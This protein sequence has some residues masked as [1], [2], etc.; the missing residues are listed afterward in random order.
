MTVRQDKKTD[1]QT[2]TVILEE[3]TLESGRVLRQ[4][5][6]AYERAGRKNGTP[7]V[8]CH[9]LTGNHHTVG[10]EERPGWWRG[11]IHEGG[12]VDLNEHEV[13]TFNVIG[14]CSGSA[15][16]LTRN[17]DSG[18]QYRSDFPF[19]SVRDMVHVQK[20]ALE[21][22]GITSIHAVLGGSLG[23]MQALEWV[24]LYPERVG[25]A[26][27]LAATSSLSDYGMAYNAI[28]RK[29]ITDD[30]KWNGGHYAANDPPVNGLALARMTGMITYRSGSLFNQRFHRETKHGPGQSH[31]EVAYQVESYLL[32]QG[33]K[34]TK[35]FDA[36]SYLY[37]LKAMDSHDL[38]RESEETL[39]ERLAPVQLPVTFISFTGDLLYPPEEMKR[40]AETFAKAGA[41]AAFFEVDTVF[42]HDGFL[43]EYS[44]WGDIVRSALE[45]PAEEGK[46]I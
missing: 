40:L 36:N 45:K 3:V 7:V 23:G 19:I 10:T 29:A 30:P 14:G 32:Y 38:E 1:S 11:L 33:D 9:A 44:K 35:R 37:L 27:I 46:A 5:E 12:Y 13:F 26:V 34:F 6:T 15:G 17:P 28:A 22:L 25:Q 20:A 31:D 42:G 2:G 43:T 24:T 8:V 21:K 18:A 16:P 41:K 39:Q 4:V